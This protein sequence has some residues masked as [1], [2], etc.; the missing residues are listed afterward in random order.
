MYT[1]EESLSWLSFKK[2]ANKI[3]ARAV[4]R[5]RLISLREPINL[6]IPNRFIRIINLRNPKEILIRK[7]ASCGPTAGP[8]SGS[9]I[10]GYV[11]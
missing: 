5:F 1:K 9:E 11:Y 7:H 3:S 8:G 4:N 2:K 10:I 6:K